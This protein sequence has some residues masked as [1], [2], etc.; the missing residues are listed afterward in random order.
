MN[1]YYYHVTYKIVFTDESMMYSTDYYPSTKVGD[2][3]TRFQLS[4]L[5]TQIEHMFKS[6]Y[7]Y[8]RICIISCIKILDGE[9]A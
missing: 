9:W 2:C 8:F 7:D 6:R 4:E 1:Q 3:L 5:N